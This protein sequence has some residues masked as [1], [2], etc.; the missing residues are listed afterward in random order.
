M[1]TKTQTPGEIMF[2]LIAGKLIQK[3]RGDKGLT[4]TRLAYLAGPEV[5]QV[6]MCRIERAATTPPMWMLHRVVDALGMSMADFFKRCERALRVAN[7][8][9]P[10]AVSG[11]EVYKQLPPSAL[12]GLATFVVYATEADPEKE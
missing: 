12:E 2:G 7:K 8:V 3:R 1:R 6:A 9:L 10:H 11:A 4:Q 5:T